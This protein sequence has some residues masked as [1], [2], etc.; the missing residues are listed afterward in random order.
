[1]SVI[2]VL[3]GV[4]S[5]GKTETLWILKDLLIEKGYEQVYVDAVY[6][7]DFVAVFRT[8]N[9]LLG[10][11]GAGNRYTSLSNQISGLILRGCEN[12]VCSCLTFDRST[13][14]RTAIDQF[15]SFDI[16]YIEK[17]RDYNLS[18]QSNSN[19]TDAEMLFKEIDSL[20]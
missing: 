2:V 15:T 5:S 14:T 9:K 18:T 13:G 6:W 10:I 1:M 20:C 12:I 7:W 19:K 8:G 4:K 16:R 3:R 11:T 17:T